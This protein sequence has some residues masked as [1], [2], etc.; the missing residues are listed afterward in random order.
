M[1]NDE[2]W[3]DSKAHGRPG[4]RVAEAG[5]GQVALPARIVRAA[6]PLSNLAIHTWD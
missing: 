3:S 2:I 1:V 5:G 4:V 6:I